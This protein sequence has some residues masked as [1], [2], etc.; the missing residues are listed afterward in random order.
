MVLVGR[1]HGIAVTS[2]VG[3]LGHN[4]KGISGVVWNSLPVMYAF[5]ADSMISPAPLQW[6]KLTGLPD[7]IS[8]DIH[9]LVTSLSIGDDSTGT[10]TKAYH[11]LLEI[12]INQ[13]DQN[14]LIY[15]IDEAQPGGSPTRTTLTNVATSSQP[16]TV[17]SDM[18]VAQLKIAYPDQVMIVAG[19]DSTG[20]LWQSSGLWSGGVDIAAPATHVLTLVDNAEWA[21]GVRAGN[22]TSYAAPLVA[23][24]AVAL[25]AMVPGLTAH[26][27]Q[28]FIVRG[29]QEPRIDSLG[30]SHLG[31]QVTGAT[32]V[33]LLDA[34]GALSLLSREIFGAPI[35]GY[36]VTVDTSFQQL[37]LHRTSDQLVSLTRVGNVGNISIAQGGRELAVTGVDSGY[38]GVVTA[39]L[40]NGSWG[41]DHVFRSF[42]RRQFLE[43]DTVDFLLAADSTP[44]FSLGSTLVQISGPGRTPTPFNP[45]SAQASGSSADVGGYVYSISPDGS[46]AFGYLAFVTP[47]CPNVTQ[48]DLV[49]YLVPLSGGAATTVYTVPDPHLICLPP[50]YPITLDFGLYSMAWNAD[51]SKALLPFLKG[52]VPSSGPNLDVRTFL[53]EVDLPTGSSRTAT[54]DHR[55]L[56]YQRYA[57]SD[58]EIRSTET[59]VSGNC[60]SVRRGIASLG[61]LFNSTQD[62]TSFNCDSWAPEA[63]NAPIMKS[64]PAMFLSR[65]SPFGMDRRRPIRP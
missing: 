56:V 18:A 25:N 64:S 23:G 59:D 65:M 57:P 52:D 54:L 13:S 15:A 36:P 51:G 39:S 60:H 46:Y 17:A 32:G 29:A 22:G 53:E 28:D 14:L 62:A 55:W 48:A 4:G 11:D 30:A 37:V 10:A 45:L 43:E 26:Q 40:Q 58:L 49:Y 34:Y 42:L 3:A 2:V 44:P 33:Y 12:W 1:S 47:D 24:V 19:S 50:T 20:A 27:V 35:C 31:V 8:R 9:I 41:V 16:N 38:Y 7:L 6:L 5:G 61:D 63:P 21:G